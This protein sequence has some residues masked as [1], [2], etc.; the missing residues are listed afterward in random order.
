MAVTGVSFPFKLAAV[1]RIVIKVCIDER[2][3]QK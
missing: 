2:Y 1:I 3:L